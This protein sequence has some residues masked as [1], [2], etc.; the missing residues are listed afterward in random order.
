LTQI[1]DQEVTIFFWSKTLNDA[2][3]NY[4]ITHIELLAVVEAV[5]SYDTYLAGASSTIRTDLSA[6]ERVLASAF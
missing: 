2:L 3:Q 6:L 5:D 4:C 1:Q